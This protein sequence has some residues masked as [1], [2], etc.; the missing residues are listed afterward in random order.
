MLFKTWMAEFYP[1]EQIASERLYHD[2]FNE[3]F[4]YGFHLPRKDQCELCNVYS[5]G[6]E[7][8][9]ATIQSKFET[10]MKENKLAIA[11]KRQDRKDAGNQPTKIVF[12]TTDLQKQLNTPQD[13][14]GIL[15][16]LRKLSTYNSTVVE[17][18]GNNLTATCY[19]W[20]EVEGKR[21]ANEVASCVR[22][23]ILKIKEEKPEV[24]EIRIWADNCFGQ[25]KNKYMFAMLL[26]L[27][28]KLRVTIKMRFL[29]TGHT[30][31]E[32][33]CVHGHIEDAARNKSVYTSEQWYH[34]MEHEALTKAQ[35]KYKVFRM[36]GKILNFHPLAD[37][38]QKWSQKGINWKKVR[39]IVFDPTKSQGVVSV[40]DS[41]ASD[42][43]I[44]E[45]DVT[46]GV[47]G[48]PRIFANFPLLPAYSGPL[49]INK[50]KL[51][52]LA[53]L[54][55][56]FIIPEEH[57]DFYKSLPG[58]PLEGGAPPVTAAE[59]D[60]GEN[61]AM[62]LL[63]GMEEPEEDFENSLREFN[64]VNNVAEVPDRN[65]NDDDDDDDD[66]DVV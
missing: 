32:S 18:A 15:Y 29:E 24:E 38:Y 13:N 11:L 28:H 53:T 30:M 54:C 35:T 40:R 60:D 7:A 44:K 36:Q 47:V 62:W 39:E 58:I 27:A 2:H 43:P 52:D 5:R 8:F 6:N 10:H 31:M 56:K 16:Y 37:K 61:E 9:K 20:N 23:F 55:K 66:G 51:K 1:T 3:N 22:Q 17:A 46:R 25:N 63:D 45:I 34:I 14:T 12:A 19:V 42:A 41:L 4:N 57:H 48:R 49:Q 65:L 64:R 26:M 33:D 59:N 50:N 21:G